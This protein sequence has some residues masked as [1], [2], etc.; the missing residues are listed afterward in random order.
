MGYFPA[1]KLCGVCAFGQDDTLV[2][3]WPLED[4]VEKSQE[5]PSCGV[6]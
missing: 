1:V 4:L 2:D 5:L 6:C 3:F